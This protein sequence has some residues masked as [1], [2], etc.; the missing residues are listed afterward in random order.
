MPRE[1]SRLSSGTRRLPLPEARTGACPARP[2]RIAAA[3]LAFALLA[4]ACA[5]TFRA[6][7]PGVA[8]RA[9]AAPS[10][11][12]SLRVSVSGRDTRGRSRALVAYRR[13]DALRIEIPGPSG[14]R[15]VAVARGGRLTAVLPADRAFLERDATASGLDALIGV[16]LSPAELMDVLAGRRP[17]SLLDYRADW[18][19]SWPR[20]VEA[21][22]AD[23]TRLKATVEAA[24]A[25]ADVSPAAF[26]PPPH[27][28]YREVE[29]DEARRLLGGR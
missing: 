17:P 14:A 7:A 15:L 1:R 19:P 25:G 13:P 6:A 4:A 21:V 23:G 11:S 20:R 9:A 24:D 10:Y 5:G 8:E 18:G 2:A 27:P 22:L 12:G 28:G 16:A 3:A 29:P 26:D